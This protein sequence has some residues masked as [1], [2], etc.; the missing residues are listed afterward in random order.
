MAI[1]ENIVVVKMDEFFTYCIIILYLQIVH[2][3][4][5]YHQSNS[6]RV[7]TKS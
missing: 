5:M 2:R 3:M 6:K 1:V 4:H 7:A